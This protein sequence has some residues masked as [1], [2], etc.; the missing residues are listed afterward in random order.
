MEDSR[1]LESSQARLNLGSLSGF[2]QRSEPQ[3]FISVSKF[4]DE[5]IHPLHEDAR[6]LNSSKTTAEPKDFAPATSV[7]ESV[8]S[9]KQ[10]TEVMTILESKPL[11]IGGKPDGF[12]QKTG[13]MSPPP[14]SYCSPSGVSEGA[15]VGVSVASSGVISG[16]SGKRSG[17]R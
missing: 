5:S 9:G 6:R 10:A 13:R 12:R 14:S 15:S 8:K 16:S 17:N 3:N 1:L 4:G 11:T 7:T 2:P